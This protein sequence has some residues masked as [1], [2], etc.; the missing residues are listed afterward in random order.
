MKILF[1]PNW[2]I[3]YRKSYDP[4]LPSPDVFYD[5][6]EYWFF[7]YWKQFNCKV[8][9]IDYVQYPIIN[10]IDKIT[11]LHF[12]QAFRMMAQKRSY[13]LVI[14]HSANS[15]LPINILNN[16][17]KKINKPHILFDIG[18]INGGK[19]NYFQ[20]NVL[21]K[22]VNAFSCIF[23][24]S[25]NQKPFYEKFFPEIAPRSY[26]VPFGI[27]PT[28][29]KPYKVN[30]KRQAI[31]IGYAKRDWKT[32]LKAF[33]NINYPLLILGP[34]NINIPSNNNNIE[35]KPRVSFSEMIHHILESK[36]VILPVEN[37]PYSLGQQTL[38][39]SMALK[40]TVIVSKVPGIV[41]YIED[42]LD[43]ILYV[44]QDPNDLKIKIETIISNPK[45]RIEI[46]RNARNSVINKFTEEKM[47]KSI[48]SIITNNNIITKTIGE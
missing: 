27:D 46:G 36:F 1:C 17:Y 5:E 34:S 48:L 29:I 38:L 11:K 42:G 44:D 19:E 9:P 28:V 24:H 32:L 21:R 30:E 45:K 13:D 41:D 6:K 16:Y 40:K 8:I 26:F 12:F 10:Q 43:G 33:E 2:K 47:A 18:L 22:Y 37:V 4:L 25:S 35:I 3:H 14:S 20:L 23:Y 15:G 7:K 39:Q 31:S